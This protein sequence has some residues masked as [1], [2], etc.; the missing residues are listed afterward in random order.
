M[1]DFFPIK[2]ETDGDE[3]E[4]IQDEEARKALQ[5]LSA[6]LYDLKERFMKIVHNINEDC[7][8]DAEQLLSDESKGMKRS[9]LLR[10]SL[11]FR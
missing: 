4:S 11:L 3:H 10:N 1:I 8:A 9:R 7:N 2:K 5:T 6:R